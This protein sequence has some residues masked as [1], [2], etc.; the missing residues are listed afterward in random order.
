[1]SAGLTGTS[2]SAELVLGLNFKLMFYFTIGGVRSLWGQNGILLYV[3]SD[4]RAHISIS[5]R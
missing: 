3:E 5:E 2:S 1:M 4:F